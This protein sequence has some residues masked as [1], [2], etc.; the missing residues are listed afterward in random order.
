MLCDDFIFV[1]YSEE[2][3]FHKYQ[4]KELT[5]VQLILQHSFP[6][7]KAKGF[8]LKKSDYNPKDNVTRLLFS[9]VGQHYAIM[10]KEVSKTNQI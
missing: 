5:E 3:D 4:V 10:Y 2:S 6:H 7:K 1:G 8:E 9:F